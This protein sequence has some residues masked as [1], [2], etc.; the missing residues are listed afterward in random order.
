MT[1]TALTFRYEL[2]RAVAAGILETAATTFL[3]LIAVRWFH[4]GST[5]KA[6]IATGGSAGMLLAPLI[7]RAASSRCFTPS[8]A[9]SFLL[10]FGGCSFL[11]MAAFP[12]LEVFVPASLVA[13]AASSGILPL[14]T[15]M[16]KENYP[17]AERGR[18]FS[19][20]VS[21][22]ISSAAIFSEA[23]GRFL[24][25]DLE[26]FRVV[27][28]LFAGAS[29]YA[30]LCLRRCPTL[31]LTPTNPVWFSG[32][33]QVWADRL[34]RSTLICWMLMG[35]GNLMMVPL[36]IE[37]L[38]NPRY[39]LALSVGEIALYTG[40]I[41]NVARFLMSPL[42]GA[43]FDRI[44]FF[45]LRIVL[46]LGFVAGIIAFFTSDGTTGLLLGSLM[47]GIAAAGGDIAWNLWVTK[48]A[49]V[50][51]TADYMAIHSC[52]TGLRGVVA[53]FAAFHLLGVFEIQ[54]IAML[55]V[56]LILAACGLLVQ[57]F[58]VTK[59]HAGR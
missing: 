12:T 30:V 43:L 38:A 57:E 33:R 48:F 11:L 23:A 10:F 45:R 15:Q 55:A 20:S 44:D 51:K 14:L 24:A 46:N 59:V 22:K 37:Y 52:F 26:R 18:L 16:Y 58:L 25:G 54:T 41:P 47:F 6:I 17:D 39:G 4:A 1:P 29:F 53:P 28:L 56:A 19:K 9:A 7:L 21:I 3:L 2:R 35:F 27:L 36:R 50:E 49:P 5:A 34:F 8:G 31:P 32:L 13:L 42:W 40:V